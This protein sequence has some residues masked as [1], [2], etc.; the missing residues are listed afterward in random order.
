MPDVILSTTRM[1]QNITVMCLHQY[2][3]SAAGLIA[4]I[5][6]NFYYIHLRLYNLLRD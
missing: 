4:S 3:H 6:G 2:A 5:L 1:A